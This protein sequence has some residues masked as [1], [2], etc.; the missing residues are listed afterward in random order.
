MIIGVAIKHKDLMVCLP[1]PNR[2]PDCIRYARDV[3]GITATPIA[4]QKDQGFYTDKGV[5]LNRE[6]ALIYARE[7]NQLIRE[8]VSK[9]LFSENL[10]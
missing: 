2:H 7:H 8:V 4:A 9:L 5:Y 1:K 6:D 10:W 3:V